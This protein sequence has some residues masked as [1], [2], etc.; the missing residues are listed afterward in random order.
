MLKDLIVGLGAESSVDTANDFSLSLAKAFNLQIVGTAFA[1]I[2]IYPATTP[3]EAFGVDF[4]GAQQLENRKAANAAI[5]RF[6][7]AAREIG[8]DGRTR[9]LEGP[10]ANVSRQ[11][12]EMAR[13]FDIAV[14]GQAKPDYWESAMIIEA[15][16]FEAGRP[17]VV[18]PYIHGSPMKLD[19]ITVCWDGSRPAARAIADAMP[20]LE[21]A[22]KVDLLTIATGANAGLPGGDMEDHLTRHGVSAAGKRLVAQRGDEAN[23]ILNHAADTGTDLIVMGG[24]GHTRLREFILGG[25]TLGILKS[26]TAPVLLSH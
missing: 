24:Y 9:T 23:T 21:R 13:C 6:Q 18:V 11:F 4:I 5:A 26:M 15:T 17:V 10:V 1:F 14:V 3:M 7:R 20:F 22:Q 25:A 2:P 12:A 16:L 19:H 8:V